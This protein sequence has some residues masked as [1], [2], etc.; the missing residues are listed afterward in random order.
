MTMIIVMVVI[1]MLS[2]AV[3]VVVDRDGRARD[4]PVLGVR[5]SRELP[6]RDRSFVRV[7]APRRCPAAWPGTTNGPDWNAV[8]KLGFGGLRGWLVG[9]LTCFGLPALFVAV[10]VY[11]PWLNPAFVILPVVLIPIAIMWRSESRRERESAAR[12]NDRHRA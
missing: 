5:W 1:V 4:S 11:A 2:R 12:N 10:L 9:T 8:F 6:R 7:R 3:V